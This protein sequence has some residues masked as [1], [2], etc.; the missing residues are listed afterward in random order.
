MAENCA[1]DYWFTEKL[2]DAL[3]TGCIPIYYGCPSIGKFFNIEGFLIFKNMAEFDDLMDKYVT[4]EYYNEIKDKGI[5]K[6]NFDKAQEY[7]TPEDYMYNKVF[8]G[9]KL[10]NA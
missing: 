5:L 9:L 4:E 7:L 2:I 8:K 3:V 6:E 10:D 1:V